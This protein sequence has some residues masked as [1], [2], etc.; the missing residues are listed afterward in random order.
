MPFTTCQNHIT[1]RGE[2]F[3]EHEIAALGDVPFTTKSWNVAGHIYRS[4]AFAHRQGQY[5]EHLSTTCTRQE[6]VDTSSHDF[7]LA[8]RRNLP[9]SRACE[10]E[11]RH[12]SDSVRSW[13][14][15]RHTYVPSASRHITCHPLYY[16][17]G[18]WL[19]L[20]PT[21]VPT[22]VRSEFLSYLPLP[23]HR[24]CRRPKNANIYLG[25]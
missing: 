14:G 25:S 3:T 16:S 21:T 9:F 8:S 24:I 10:A 13:A 15:A 6:D 1:L 18:V 4:F 7:F 22:S 5:G 12:G 11:D 2:D 23:R 19:S 20:F 17:F